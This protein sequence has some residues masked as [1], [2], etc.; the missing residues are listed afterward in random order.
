MNTQQFIKV[1]NPETAEKLKS[2]GFA[3]IKENDMFVF[4]ITDELLK[5]IN[6]NFNTEQYVFDNKLC[7]S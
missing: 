7:F 6:T 3:Y 1:L 4:Q 2:L 5:E